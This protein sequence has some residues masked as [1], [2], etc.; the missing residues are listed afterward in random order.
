MAVSKSWLPVCAAL[1]MAGLLGLGMG[2]KGK[3]GGSSSTH[4]VSGVVTYTR[5]P[6]QT[7]AND[8]PLGLE[9]GDTLDVQAPARGVS[10]RVFQSQSQID[11]NGNPYTVW[12]VAGTGVTDING[13]YSVNNL[14]D[15]NSTF[16][17][18][19]SVA[20]AVSA[21]IILVGDPGG[22]GST[23]PEPS[24]AI[25]CMRQGVDGT[26]STTNP[27]PGAV[28]SGDAAV[29]FNVGLTDSWILA[30]L[31]WYRPA[32]AP[33]PV[34]VTV[35]AG[36]R[37]L[38]ILDSAYTFQYFY[39]NPAPPA[40]LD[41]HYNPAIRDPRG[42][43]VEYD[44]TKYPYASDGS[45]LHYFGSIAGNRTDTVGGV[46]VTY[47][48]DAFNEG[49]IF[50]LLGRNNLVT[51][52]M[53]VL[54]PT[55]AD[56][57]LTSEAPPVAVID[58]L[59][60]VMAASLLQSP[61]LLNT[62]PGGYRD[63]SDISSLTP[64]QR[65]AFSVPNISALGWE[66]VL[67]ANL[68]QAP[69]A[70]WEWAMINPSVITRLFGLI[71]P[72]TNVV[73]AKGNTLTP[74][75]GVSSIYAQLGRMQEVQAS[76]D[77]VNLAAIFPDQLMTPLLAKYNLAWPGIL[78]LPSYTADWGQDPDALT[79]PLQPFTLSMAK[80]VPVRG[81]YPNVSEGEVTFSQFNLT[82]DRAFN[83]TFTTVPNL[84]AGAQLEV[85]V[86][87]GQGG[88]YLYN[89]NGTPASDS[90]RLELRGNF[91]DTTQPVW[92]YL[93]LRLVSPTVLQP[94]LVITPHLD[95]ASS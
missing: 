80:A 21:P 82:L 42:S 11:T 79:K 89:G 52:N 14:V 23:V 9:D 58:G 78:N 48:G 16:V 63:I 71:L 60:D 27:T 56:P 45:N 32:I 57:P 24:R 50:R 12:V 66:M 35:A 5:K 33:F 74:I 3:G 38:A 64:S 65:T 10:V 28:L 73:T 88:I 59:A 44:L 85:T 40:P 2:C 67:D 68:I 17:E 6:L 92:H 1:L 34:P 75:T 22:V 29:N 61:Y 84:P 26:L 55:E 77:Q 54:L 30:P 36:S 47:E 53:T 25:Y 46:P 20:P 7:D 62:A 18:L 41:L 51:Q 91:A 39:G 13:Y 37:V 90:Y 87:N 4:T 31:H 86:D 15:G 8:V 43:F 83:L 69:G 76:G 49:V 81:V 94:D 72:Y 19:Y 70:T 95:K 93:Q